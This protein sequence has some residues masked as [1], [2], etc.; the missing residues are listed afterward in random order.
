[1]ANTTLV[2]RKISYADRLP[3]VPAQK[4]PNFAVFGFVSAWI[5]AVSMF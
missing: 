4:A 5:S 1:M 2:W 3:L